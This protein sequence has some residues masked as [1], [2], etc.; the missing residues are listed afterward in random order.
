MSLDMKASE[1]STVLKFWAVEGNFGVALGLNME[2]AVRLIGAVGINY[3]VVVR[4]V[5]FEA[6]PGTLH[7]LNS[8]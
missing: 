4:N 8:S 2:W 3:E 1:N 7:G 6:P 5:G